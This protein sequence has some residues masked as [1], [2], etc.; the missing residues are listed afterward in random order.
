MNLAI[1]GADT[2]EPEAPG[3]NHTGIDFFPEG[4][5]SDR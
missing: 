4:Y 3:K 2:R 1:Q 5:L